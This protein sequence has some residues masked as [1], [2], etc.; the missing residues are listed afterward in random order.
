MW[1]ASSGIHVR[2]LT[3][4][5]DTIVLATNGAQ[6]VNKLTISQ[7]SCYANCDGSTSAPLLTANDFQCFLNAYAANDS[8]A[9]CD[10]STSTPILTANDFQCFLNTFAAGCS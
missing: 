3:T 10:G 5:V 7:S 2:N 6:L 9:N 1:T 8:Y 4:S